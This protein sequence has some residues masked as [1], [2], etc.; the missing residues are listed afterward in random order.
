MAKMI[1]NYITEDVKSNAEK[2]CSRCLRKHQ[3]QI[4]G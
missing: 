3:E 1:P 4:V 2:K